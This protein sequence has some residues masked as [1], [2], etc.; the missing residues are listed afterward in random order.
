MRG[1]AKNGRPS[2]LTNDELLQMISFIQGCH[3]NEGYPIYPSFLDIQD[4]IYQQF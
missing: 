2:L 4:Y 3:I 1:D